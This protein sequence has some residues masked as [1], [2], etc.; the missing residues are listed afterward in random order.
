MITG[1]VRGLA[2]GVRGASLFRRVCDSDGPERPPDR[3]P[4]GGV[5]GSVHLNVPQGA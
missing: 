5:C 3:P 1:I 2:G 4:L